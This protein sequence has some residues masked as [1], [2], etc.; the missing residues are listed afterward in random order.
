[1]R[2][3][4]D[5]SECVICKKETPIGYHKKTTGETWYKKTCSPECLSELKSNKSRQLY[6]EGITKNGFTR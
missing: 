5:K 1:M 2:G 4:L 3:L 6:K